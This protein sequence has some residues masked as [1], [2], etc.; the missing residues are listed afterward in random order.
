[1]TLDQPYAEFISRTPTLSAEE[2]QAIARRY[3]AHRDPKDAERLV[4]GNLRIV[5]K[6]ARELAGGRRV[7]LM[8][9]VQEGNA[10]LLQAV[11]RFDPTRGVKLTTYARWWIRAYMLRYIMETAR[12]VDS[13]STR[14][15]RRRFFDGTLAP[16]DVSLDVPAHRDREDGYRNTAASVESM[17]ADEDS[18]PDV[19]VA[20]REFLAVV[21]T[22][23]DAFATTLDARG[24]RVF[25]TRLL[26]DQPLRL[27]EVGA[28]LAVSSERVRQLEQRVRS[29]LRDHV[30]RRLGGNAPAAAAA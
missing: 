21:R 13:S 6:L 23:V 26:A 15:G 7:D 9:L 1:M 20:E 22:A 4:L 5:V 19:R 29:R 2:Q 10:G 12:M 30:T 25:E 14:E 18:R 3:A 24:R 17:A 28:E 8:D 16:P 11:R 27:E